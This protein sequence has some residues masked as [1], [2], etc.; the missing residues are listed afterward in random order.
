M[1]VTKVL[2]LVILVIILCIVSFAIK[3][4]EQF[5]DVPEIEQ[6]IIDKLKKANETKR[7]KNIEN[8]KKFNKQQAINEIARIRSE[9]EKRMDDVR[10]LR[11]L[12]Q[13]LPVCRDIDLLPNNI[14]GSRL[15]GFNLPELD[16]DCSAHKTK[17]ECFFGRAQ[18]KN[19]CIWEKT[20]SLTDANGDPVKDANDK[21]IKKRW[22]DI[23]DTEKAN[24]D[25]EGDGERCQLRKL[26]EKCSNIKS[27][28]A[29]NPNKYN[30][31]PYLIP[32]A[33]NSI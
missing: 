6:D 4:K 31:K 14:G 15:D 25:P 28:D 20:K 5:Y 27:Q 30:Y 23:D 12:K 26:N 22:A 29:N 21:P 19:Y 11:H 18:N 17:N 24:W 2:V 16:G 32:N 1:I 10:Q 33:F 3:K 9:I 13:V 7:S 8:Y